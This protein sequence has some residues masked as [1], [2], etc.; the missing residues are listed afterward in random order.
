[1]KKLLY[2][3]LLAFTLGVVLPEIEAGPARPVVVVKAKKK[4]KKKKQRARHKKR[5]KHRRKVAAVVAFDTRVAA[6]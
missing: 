1:M 4:K 6:T 5:I 2:L 3:V